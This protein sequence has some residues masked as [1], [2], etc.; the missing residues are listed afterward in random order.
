MRIPAIPPTGKRFSLAW[1][2]TRDIPEW[3]ISTGAHLVVSL[4]ALP[5]GG[6]GFRVEVWRDGGWED[7]PAG[8]MDVLF[9]RWCVPV[10]P[11]PRDA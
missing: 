1:V 6:Q 3:K 5:N 11:E 8:S 10:G 4:Y 7:V 2:A 9:E